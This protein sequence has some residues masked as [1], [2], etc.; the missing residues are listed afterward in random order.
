VIALLAL[1][2]SL[3][4]SAYAAFTL[5]RNS[6]GTRQLRNGAVTGAKL[7]NGAVTWRQIRGHSLRASDF[8]FGQLRAG[9]RGAQGPKGTTGSLG[10]RGA[11]GAAGPRG[12]T[13]ATGPAGP[14]Y[15]F[16]TAGGNPGPSLTQAGTY[17]VV[18]QAGISNTNPTALTGECDVSDPGLHGAFFSNAFALPPNGSR[19]FSFSGMAAVGSPVSLHLSCTDTS[20]AAVTPTAPQ[21]W[22][23]PV[24]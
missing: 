2:V 1:F 18:V 13:G 20:G 22:V 7:Q 4:G 17:F 10:P 12:H 9:E 19:E 24:G 6:V 5:P 21:W 15:H 11:T 16:T 3:G 8:A 14:G 23:S